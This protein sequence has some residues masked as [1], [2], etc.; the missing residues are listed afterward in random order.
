MRDLRHAYI[1]CFNA[2][3]PLDQLD[4]LKSLRNSHQN[5]GKESKKRAERIRT[6]YLRWERI[7]QGIVLMRRVQAYH[8]ASVAS[9]VLIWIYVLDAILYY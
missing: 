3:W 4:S 2:P 7:S 8:L 1:V 5:T 6:S 9:K